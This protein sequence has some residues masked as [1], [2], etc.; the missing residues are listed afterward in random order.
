VKSWEDVGLPLL[1]QYTFVREGVL[2]PRSV[3]IIFYAL[4]VPWY[5]NNNNTLPLYLMNVN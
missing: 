3:I 4:I 5:C 1:K 2:P